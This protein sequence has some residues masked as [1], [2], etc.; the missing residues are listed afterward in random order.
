MAAGAVLVTAFEPF[1]GATVNA[2]WEAA[3]RID[4]LRCGEAVA[5]ARLL[6]CAYDACV[7]ELALMVEALRPGAVVMTGEAARRDVVCIE[8][9]ARSRTHATALDNRGRLG[10][11]AIG[12]P[13]VV[14]TTA[15]TSALVRAIQAAGIAARVSAD[16][17]E[18][19]CNHLYYHALM[20]FAAAPRPI[21]A[22]F[23]HLPAVPGQRA[24]GH[25]PR[26][27]ETTDAARALRAAVDVMAAQP[28]LKR[29]GG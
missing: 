19:V 13:D 29:D 22:V 12:G 8:R 16:A 14:E 9:L 1:G 2:S 20:R 18:Y 11:A 4:G 27:L 10:S 5:I 15:P 21:P 28:R 24:G 7:A 6:P 26:G 3:R 17:G 25:R 23:V